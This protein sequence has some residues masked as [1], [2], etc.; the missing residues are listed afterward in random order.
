MNC[1]E[2]RIPGSA[3]AADSLCARELGVDGLPEVQSRGIRLA[4]FGGL[5]GCRQRA[6]KPG[7]DVG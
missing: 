2:S 6:G 1:P 7:L 3:A 4:G 5:S